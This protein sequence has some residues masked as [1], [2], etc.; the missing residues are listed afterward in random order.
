MTRSRSSLENLAIW[1]TGCLFAIGL[2]LGFAQPGSTNEIGSGATLFQNGVW[3]LAAIAASIATWYRYNQAY[4]NGDKLESLW[5]IGGKQSAVCLVGCLAVVVLASVVMG[6][7]ANVRQALNSMWQWIAIFAV[8]LVALFWWW[9]TSRPSDSIRTSDDKTSCVQICLWLMVIAT[10]LLACHGLYQHWVSLPADLATYLANP[11][12]TL[13]DARIDAPPG[14]ATRMLFESRLNDL[15]PTATFSLTNSL[16]SVLAMASV[17]CIGGLSCKW[18]TASASRPE[19]GQQDKYWLSRLVLA[20]LLMLPLLTCLALTKSRTSWLAFLIGAALLIAKSNWMKQLAPAKKSGLIIG[21]VGL[22]AA[23]AIGIYV[24]D[25]GIFLQAA[26]SLQYRIE[27]WQTTLR[28]FAAHWW[29][30]IGPGNFQDYYVQ[31]KPLL[32]AEAVADPHSLWFQTL[33]TGGPLAALCLIAGWAKFF[34]TSTH[35]AIIDRNWS[36]NKAVEAAKNF[37]DHTS[38]VRWSLAIGVGIGCLLSLLGFGNSDIQIDPV[39]YMFSLPLALLLLLKIRAIRRKSILCFD[40]ST[41]NCGIATGLISLTFSDGWMTAGVTNL[42]VLMVVAVFRIDADRDE[43]STV[44]RKKNSGA[45]LVFTCLSVA[46]AFLW[47]TWLPVR[48]AQSAV[49]QMQSAS[50][51]PT[52]EQA[53]Q[54]TRIDPLDPIMWRLAGSII[55]AQLA[56]GDRIL[57]ANLMK[58]FD[59]ICQ[60]YL[61]ANRQDWEAFTQVGHWRFELTR[62]DPSELSQALTYYARAAELYPSDVEVLMQAALVAYLLDDRATSEGWLTKA[63]WIDKNSPHLDRH[64]AAGL[65]YWPSPGSSKI[66]DSAAAMGLQKS[67]LVSSPRGAGWIEAEPL[68]RALRKQLDLAR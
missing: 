12:Q 23:L 57:D 7:Q 67:E 31:Y 11:D 63:E 52:A 50:Q 49:V 60:R 29:L 65:V 45:V 18:P 58:R 9:L 13:R 6:G 17:L 15:A 56:R 43:K 2:V 4:E 41:L 34:W 61:A 8:G 3:L 27:Y 46:M 40:R 30:G 47:T 33:V 32:S 35:S 24:W 55:Q 48:N 5:S 51:G 1:L 28:I 19:A 22:I 62:L 37:P 53:E 39:P 10:W 21:G 26:Q 44:T 59:L 42:I 54:L 20:I 64:L 16:A 68:A 66:G 14:S 38:G 36:K 25:V